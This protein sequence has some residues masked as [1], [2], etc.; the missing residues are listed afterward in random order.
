MGAN[1]LSSDSITD[2]DEQ[3]SQLMQ[4]KPLSELQVRVPFLLV[5]K[6]LGQKIANGLPDCVIC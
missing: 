3:I 2:L 5:S 4:C 1:P 6:K